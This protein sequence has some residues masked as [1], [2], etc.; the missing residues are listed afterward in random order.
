MISETIQWISKDVDVSTGRPIRE[1]LFNARG[2]LDI[3]RADGAAKNV[4]V[5]IRSA[6]LWR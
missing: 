1:L 4:E 6:R 2:Q 5:A 3:K